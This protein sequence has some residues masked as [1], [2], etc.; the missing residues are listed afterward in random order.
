MLHTAFFSA[1]LVS[2]RCKVSW[3]SEREPMVYKGI[4]SIGKSRAAVKSG[5]VLSKNFLVVTVMSIV[6]TVVLAIV[7]TKTRTLPKAGLV[8]VG[9]GETNLF[10]NW[11]RLKSIHSL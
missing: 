1:E 7:F 10:W 3:I 4:W 9:S 5:W 8:I 11:W 2:H 6:I